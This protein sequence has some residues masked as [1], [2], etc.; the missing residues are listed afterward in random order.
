MAATPP[1]SALPGFDFPPVPVDYVADGGEDARVQAL[2]ELDRCLDFGTDLQLA[3]WARRWGRDL[4]RDTVG[5][6]LQGTIADLEEQLADA[7][8]DLRSAVRDEDA[9]LAVEELE[10]AE[11]ALAEVAEAGGIDDGDHIATARS[12]ISAALKRLG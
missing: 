10:A 5:A 8:A 11:E 1:Q 7:E 2:H 9:A 6:G 4:V 3:A 12:K